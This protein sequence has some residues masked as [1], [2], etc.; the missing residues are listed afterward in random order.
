MFDKVKA[1]RSSF[2]ALCYRSLIHFACAD[3]TGLIH[4]HHFVASNNIVGQQKA[5]ISFRLTEGVE[6]YYLSNGL[7]VLLKPVKSS[8]SV[9]T[10]I[11]YRVGSRNE[12]LGKTGASH[13]CEH[14][15][16]KG[17]GKLAKGDI[18]NLV[19]SEGG[20]N[21]AFTD[22]DVTA[23]YETLPKERLNLGLFI[24]S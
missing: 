21:N 10:W 3:G 14:M 18:F 23:Y 13:W 12:R 11:F 15:L 20:R 16:F 19:S 9:S 17:G 4:G 24:E 22:H 8:S 2:L 1:F 6:E 5:G 7:Q